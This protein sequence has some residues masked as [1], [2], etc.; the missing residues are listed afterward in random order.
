MK[1]DLC[2]WKLNNQILEEEKYVEGIFDIV[3]KL[4][5]GR[6]YIQPDEV[7]MELKRSCA[8][9]SIKYSKEKSKET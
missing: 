8:S 4:E 3:K 2:V 6:P 1:E 9:F 7:W 5:Y